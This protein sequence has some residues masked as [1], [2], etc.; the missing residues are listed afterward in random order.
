MA[1]VIVVGA[2]VSGLSAAR[3]LR[4]HGV[5][6]V[7]LEARDRVGGRT[8]TING[9][10]F[11]Y[12]DIGGA[13]IGCTQNNVLGLLQEL[14]L[15]DKL[16]AVYYEDKT[17]FT[18]KG[19]RFETIGGVFPSFWNPLVN[20]DINNFFRRLD[21]MGEEIPADAPWNAP[22]AEE[23]DRMTFQEFLKQTCWTSMGEEMGRF[24]IAINVTSDAY[25]GSLLWLLWYVKQCGG[26]KRIIS[27]KNGGQEYKMK[28]GMMQI[29]KR[30][31]EQLSD[32]VKLNKVVV[33]VDQ[34]PDQVM[35]KTL[36]GNEYKGSHI[37]MALAPTMQAKI[38]YSPPLPPLRNQLIQ[39]MPMGSVW[40]CLVYYKEPFWRK[41]KYS[42]S[43]LFTLS[44]NCPVVYTIDDTK[45][46]GSYPAIIGFLP[47]SKARE[48]AALQPLE[49]RNMII[50]GYARAMKTEEALHP[51]HY[52]EYNWAT[53]QYAGGCYTAMMPPGFLTS[54][55]SVL[56]DP[57]GR[58]YFAGTETATQWSG[59]INGAI[60]A[61]ERA[62]KE[63]L[64]SM[65]KIPMEEVWAPAPASD[66]LEAVPFVDTFWE[67]HLPSVPGFLTLLGL[68]VTPVCVAAC[69]LLSKSHIGQH[70]QSLCRVR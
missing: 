31:A 7:V 47:A 32:S 13:Y 62:A 21:E 44:D 49:R 9:E 50:S 4:K 59:Y 27:I 22:H 39:R 30:M 1:P 51:I 17:V 69:F 63:V 68:T 16:Y 24:F 56:R 34:T 66:L 53:E 70:L 38:H 12:L 52:E 36:D 15:Q 58:M 54:F 64:H 37:I 41:I 20:M 43:M 35:V 14:G 42:G 26:V 45:P 18:I 19:K 46:D 33:S 11:G 10:H 6:V 25:E 23:W 3:L 65:G 40:K 60:Q 8:Y 28:G 29:S 61:G 67:K 48:L 57:I 55:R 2:G 5:D